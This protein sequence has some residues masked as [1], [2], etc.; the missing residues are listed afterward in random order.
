M[1]GIADGRL[2][3][4]SGSDQRIFERHLK[5]WIGRFFSDLEAAGAAEFYARV[6]TVGRVFIA[7]ETEAAALP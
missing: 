3:V 4:P 5:P 1:A 2:P 6:G 7:I